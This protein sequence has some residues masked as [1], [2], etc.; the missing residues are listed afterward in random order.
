[1]KSFQVI[2]FG[3]SSSCRHVRLS[4]FFCFLVVCIY[5]LHFP[6]TYTVVQTVIRIRKKKKLKSGNA[7]AWPCSWKIKSQG[8][9]SKKK[10]ERK[11]ERKKE[12]QIWMRRFNTYFVVD[13]PTIRFA[14]LSNDFEEVRLLF[15]FFTPLLT[16]FTPVCDLFFFIILLL[17]LLFYI[18]RIPKHNR[19]SGFDLCYCQF[20]GLKVQ[21]SGNDTLLLEE[22]GVLLLNLAIYQDEDCIPIIRIIN[23]NILTGNLFLTSDFQVR[24]HVILSFMIAQSFIFSSLFSANRRLLQV[25]LSSVRTTPEVCAAPQCRNNYRNQVNILS[26]VCQH[27]CYNDPSS[28]RVFRADER[29]GKLC[30][31]GVQA[32]S[33]DCL[34]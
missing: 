10:K 25:R 16:T 8:F 6:S 22:D 1:M 20:H 30:F 4:H 31:F 29:L 7:Q 3:L 27:V 24:L 13:N 12:R 28:I 15:Q 2:S 19:Q 17:L 26:I 11:R 34:I 23:T 9:F 5:F 32:M 14:F 33:K 18:Y 21:S